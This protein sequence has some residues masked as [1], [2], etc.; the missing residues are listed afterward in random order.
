MIRKV[1]AP[2]VLSLDISNTSPYFSLYRDLR[3][4]IS[5]FFR[6]R[7]HFPDELLKIKFHVIHLYLNTLRIFTQKKET[8]FVEYQILYR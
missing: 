5:T 6:T 2:L 1:C 8:K 7:H 3:L 4:L